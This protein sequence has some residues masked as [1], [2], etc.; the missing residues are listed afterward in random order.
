MFE[1]GDAGSR[2]ERW[3]LQVVDGGDAEGQEEEEG[4]RRQG[5]RA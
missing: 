5:W 3:D 4:T 2:R 1:G